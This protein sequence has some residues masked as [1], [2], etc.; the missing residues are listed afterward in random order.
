MAN[1][2]PKWVRPLSE[3]GPLAVF[4]AVY[5]STKDLLEATA[6]ILGA[7]ALA[8]ALLLYYERRMPWMPV[9][10][11]VILA[12]FGGLTL[13]TQ[14]DFFL[15]IRPTIVQLLF[16]AI[17]LVGLFFKKPLLELVLGQAVKLTHSGW[18][19][20]SIR[21]ALFFIAM[22]A[23]N[24]YVWRTQT[25]EFWVLFKFPGLLILTVLFGLT[26]APFLVREMREME[27]KNNDG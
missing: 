7:T 5:W 26:Q 2:A 10:T 19:T 3:Y 4:L 6:W 16:A 25:E 23:L 17:L 1:T 15:K 24:E 12:I 18:R 8:V 11:A 20:F 14:D 9:F 13:F 27:A 21:Y 22:A